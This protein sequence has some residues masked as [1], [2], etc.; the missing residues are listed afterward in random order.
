M[1]TATLKNERSRIVPQNAPN[2]ELQ[3]MAYTKAVIAIIIVA[4]V[5]G[6]MVLQIQ[7]PQAVYNILFIIVGAYFGYSAKMYND[8][9]HN[10]KK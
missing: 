8:A 3:I 6:S 7:L 2:G 10:G 1:T 9:Y 4:T 5:M